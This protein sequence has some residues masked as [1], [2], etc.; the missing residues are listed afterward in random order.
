MADILIAPIPVP[1]GS[2]LREQLDIWDM[3]QRELA[4]RMGTSTKHLNEII[5]GK[6]P[7]T[8]ETALKLERVLG[9]PASFWTGLEAAYQEA[10]ARAE[11]LIIDDEEKKIAQS[12]SYAE[13][14]KLGW[15]EKTKSIGVKIDNLRSFFGIAKLT[16]IPRL[17]P[18]AFR[19]SNCYDSSDL[20]LAVWLRKGEVIA[21]DIQTEKFRK[22]KLKS[23]IPKIRSLTLN[24]T[25][26]T[27]EILSS[28]LA[29]SGIALAIV[30]HISKT[31]VN[32]AVK[33]IS[34]EKALLQ[35]SLK[36]GYAD[37]F[38]FSLFHEIGHIYLGHNKKDTIVEV[39]GHNSVMER[40]ADNFAKNSL[41]PER[42]W[43]D[44]VSGSVFSQ[45]SIETFAEKEKIHTGIVVGRLM[46][47]KLISFNKFT[48][49]REK[50][51]FL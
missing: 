42:K 8:I 48:H 35:L 24:T 3:T 38:W 7:I 13:I 50:V 40:D 46:H 17:M 27:I 5:K 14:A 32:G 43:S 23:I 25:D 20:S 45:D 4:L 15:V 18:V 44:F 47:D 16:Y 1:P 2:T 19:K 6:S 34:S 33:W 51:R 22:S 31:H 12:I 41:I 37:I 49:L 39:S 28:L 29:S 10:K 21:Q 36:G 26:E 9:L 11:E 30:P